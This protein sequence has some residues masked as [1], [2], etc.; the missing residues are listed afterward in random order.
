[1]ISDDTRRDGGRVL[2]QHRR[3]A[4]ARRGGHQA[5]PATAYSRADA[6]RSGRNSSAVM[7]VILPTAIKCRAG[8]RS[9]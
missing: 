9:Q 1:M 4:K 8:T 3:D 7:P 5:T 6:A 2:K